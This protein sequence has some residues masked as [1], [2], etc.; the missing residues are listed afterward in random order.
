MYLYD[1]AGKKTLILN[2]VFGGGGGENEK[3]LHGDLKTKLTQRAANG[4]V[5][6]NILEM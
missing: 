3:L 5:R 1:T 2:F 4:A 6:R